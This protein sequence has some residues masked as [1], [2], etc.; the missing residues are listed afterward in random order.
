MEEPATK[1]DNKWLVWSGVY[2][3]MIILLT[4]VVN[5]ATPYSAEPASRPE[6]WQLALWGLLYLPAIALPLAAKKKIAD[7]GFTINPYLLL[8]F[9]LISMLCAVFS[10]TSQV[11]WSSA[12]VEAFARTGEEVFFRGFLIDI[13]LQVFAK[14][15]QAWLWAVLISSLVFTLVHTQT[16]RADFLSQYGSSTEPVIYKIIE[17]LF[18]VFSLSLVFALLRVWT[19]SILPGAIAHSILNGGILTLPFVLVIY[20]AM[21][22]WAR[23][24]GEQITFGFPSRGSAA[25]ATNPGEDGHEQT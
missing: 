9:V 25:E 10:S 14:R 11:S 21:L 3:A 8:A 16:F 13:C 18:N 22:L 1:S 23:I 5:Y 20:G 17:R 12:D 6:F 15:R 24:R 19:H 2:A 4:M 7:L